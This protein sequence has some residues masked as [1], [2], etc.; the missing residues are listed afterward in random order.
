[1]DTVFTSGAKGLGGEVDGDE[2]GVDESL[3]VQDGNLHLVVRQD[4]RVH[5]DLIHR[6]EKSSQRLCLRLIA[7]AVCIVDGEESSKLDRAPALPLDLLHAILCRRDS[8]RQSRRRTESDEFRIEESRI[9]VVVV[10]ELGSGAIVFVV[11]D[12]LVTFTS[13]SYSSQRTFQDYSTSLLLEA[14]LL[15]LEV[16]FQY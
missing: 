1:M 7:R 15:P 4:R 6:H 11:S 9:T 14:G 5:I 13:F 10:N 8:T 16:H 12:V 3:G 2:C